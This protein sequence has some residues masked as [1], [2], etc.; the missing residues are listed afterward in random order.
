MEAQAVE[1]WEFDFEY[2]QSPVGHVPL[3]CSY[4]TDPRQ[5]LSSQEFAIVNYVRLY[6]PWSLALADLF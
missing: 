3:Y 5:E 1:W 2:G 6:S 4:R